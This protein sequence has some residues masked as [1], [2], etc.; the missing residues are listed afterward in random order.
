MSNA[1]IFLSKIVVKTIDNIEKTVKY[2]RY[3][4]DVK[5]REQVFLAFSESVIAFY[6]IAFIALRL[7]KSDCTDILTSQ[8]RSL[9]VYLR[10]PL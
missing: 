3:G 10:M 7:H 8:G 4:K 1:S 2:I 6:Y 9:S 5:N